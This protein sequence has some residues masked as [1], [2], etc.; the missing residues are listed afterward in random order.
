VTRGGAHHHDAARGWSDGALDGDRIAPG[1]PRL[2]AHR[3]AY[4][5]GQELESLAAPSYAPGWAVHTRAATAPISQR[6]RT[7]TVPGR[8]ARGWAGSSATASR[9]RHEGV[10]TAPAADCVLPSGA[11]AVT[12][13]WR[14]VRSQRQGRA[15][16]TSA[17]PV[18]ESVK[19]ATGS[20]PAGPASATV[21]VAPAGPVTWSAIQPVCERE[22]RCQ[23]VGWAAQSGARQRPC[24]HRGPRGQRAY[25]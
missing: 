14:A 5:A 9:P 4:L 3:G 17:A 25:R 12:V 13:S 21:A 10:W 6:S 2:E 16:A 15:C 19:V 11:V 7:C 22:A 1:M 23:S 8:P 18:A 20:G 24:R